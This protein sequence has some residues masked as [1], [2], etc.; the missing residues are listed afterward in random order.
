MSKLSIVI[1]VFNEAKTIHNVLEKIKAVELFN[2]IE[3]ELIIIN[4]CSTDYSE[5]VILSFK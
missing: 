5:D 1:P 4:D 2:C 3:K